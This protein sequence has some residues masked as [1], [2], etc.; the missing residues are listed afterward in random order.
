MTN[1]I[2]S[3]ERDCMACPA[4][5]KGSMDDGTNIYIRYRGGVFQIRE[6]EEEYPENVKHKQN[7]GGMFG[8]HLNQLEMREKLQELG[9]EFEDTAPSDFYLKRG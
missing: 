7:F 1:K 5:W 3:I 8:G 4:S 2:S 9:Y 6:G